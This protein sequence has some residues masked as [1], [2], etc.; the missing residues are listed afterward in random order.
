MTKS[1]ARFTLAYR[2]VSILLLNT[3]IILSAFTGVSYA[4]FYVHD[5]KHAPYSSFLHADA[6][7]KM[8]AAQAREVFRE[9]DRMGERE[10][11]VYQ[12]WLGFSERVFHSPRLNVD[13]GVFLPT[14]H[15]VNAPASPGKRS[16]TIWMFGG[17][18]MFGWGVPDDETVASHLAAI[19][20][21]RLPDRNVTVVNQGHSYY[22]SSQEVLLFQMLLRRG[23][24]CDAAVFFHGTNDVLNN[25]EEDRPAFADRMALM[26]AREQQDASSSRF[27][28]VLP[29]FPPVQLARAALEK[30]LPVAPVPKAPQ[31]DVAERYRFNLDVATAAGAEFGIPAYFFW[32][33]MPPPEH[34]NHRDEHVADVRRSV[35]ETNFHYIG[36]LFDG[37]PLKDIY[38]DHFHY[39]D[40]ACARLADAIAT[41]LLRTG[42]EG[43]GG[44]RLISRL[45][46]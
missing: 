5:P 19:L 26:F 17:S 6:M 39:G 36:D 40:T 18:T 22:F 29:L 4:V 38:I 7:H 14:R 37:E 20:S 44:E 32:Q 9:F 31:F 12:P 25:G 42:I 8:T 21:K 45:G 24:K 46:Q 33:P 10:T 23:Q 30:F 2:Y 34:K 43:T 16:L 41:T 11:Y 13:E 3:V 35:H 1:A 15:T 28:R 27:V